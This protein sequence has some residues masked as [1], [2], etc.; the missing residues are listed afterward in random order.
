MKPKTVSHPR[1]KKGVVLSDSDDSDEEEIIPS[2]RK[3]KGKS[4]VGFMD[5]TDDSETE[6]HK[7]ELKAMMDVDDG[8]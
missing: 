7:E 2:R 5:A 4:A 6:K 3:G 8:T 1:V